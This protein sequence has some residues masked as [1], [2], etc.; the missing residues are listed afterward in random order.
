MRH[1]VVRHK[2]T[3]IWKT[4]R[5]RLLLPRNI[6]QNRKSRDG[7][8]LLRA[9]RPNH[10]LMLICSYRIPWSTRVWESVSFRAIKEW[11]TPSEQSNAKCKIPSIVCANSIPCIGHCGPGPER[12]Q[13]WIL[14]QKMESH[15]YDASIFRCFMFSYVMSLVRLTYQCFLPPHEWP[16]VLVM[17]FP[18]RPASHP[19]SKMRGF[20]PLSAENCQNRWCGWTFFEICVWVLVVLGVF[21]VFC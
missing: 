5:E 9:M 15:G 11:Y 3:E 2:T 17:D 8:N 18:F 1:S 6:G 7:I 20:P 14:C 12:H 10:P 4:A 19:F 21:C 16:Y 13:E